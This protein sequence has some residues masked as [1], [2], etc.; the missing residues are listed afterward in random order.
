MYW[1]SGGG[2][3]RVGGSLEETP[4]VTG[5]PATVVTA[6]ASSEGVNWCVL[7][8]GVSITVRDCTRPFWSPQ[9][10]STSIPTWDLRERT[11]TP[12]VVVSMAEAADKVFV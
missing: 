3:Q 1:V 7:W 12:R 11:E 8:E 10:A 6:A 5:A 9:E 2:N 4:G